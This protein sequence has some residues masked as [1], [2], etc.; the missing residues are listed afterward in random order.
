MDMIPDPQER[1]NAA[2][3]Y[4]RQ[5]YNCT[6]S[7]LMAYSDYLGENAG[8][9]LKAG[10]PLGGGMGRLREVCGAVS[11]MFLILGSLYGYD[12][13]ETGNAKTELYSRVQALAECFEKR[14]GTI[15]CRELL[16][17][18]AGHDS[19]E[20]TPRT[21]EFYRKRPCGGLIGDAAEILAEYIREHP[22]ENIG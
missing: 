1:K 9:I 13:P 7:V 4:F 19:P 20:A 16:G 3:S 15:V 21:E 22:P 10:T 18:P 8:V 2:E 12:T 11:A 5:G 6:Q 17:L 14:H